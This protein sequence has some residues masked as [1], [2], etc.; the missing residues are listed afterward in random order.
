MSPLDTRML[1]RLLPYPQGLTQRGPCVN[2]CWTDKQ[3][4]EVLLLLHVIPYVSALCV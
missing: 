4:A 1:S 2:M 3:L